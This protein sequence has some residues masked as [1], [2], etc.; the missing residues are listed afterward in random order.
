MCFDMCS[1]MWD[2]G[3]PLFRPFS[4]PEMQEFILV[5]KMLVIA[6]TPKCESCLM[7]G[8]HFKETSL[9]HL[10]KHVCLLCNQDRSGRL[11][12]YG[13]DKCLLLLLLL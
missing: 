11:G 9:L 13:G 1:N 5:F 4:I 2:S 8:N 10:K 3:L 12:N 7:G 6:D